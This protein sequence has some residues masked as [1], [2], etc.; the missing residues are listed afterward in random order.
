MIAIGSPLTNALGIAGSVG[1]HAVS[2]FPVPESRAPG[3]RSQFAAGSPAAAAAGWAAGW[4]PAGADQLRAASSLACAAARSAVSWS[5]SACCDL[6][7]CCAC[8]SAETAVCWLASASVTAV[9]AFCLANR[10]A[11]S[12]FTCSVRAR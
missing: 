3:A 8:V 1:S 2:Q 10:A 6:N 5:S 9:S 7:V 11:D 4:P 12:L